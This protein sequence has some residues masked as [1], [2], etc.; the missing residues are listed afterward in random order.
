MP[1]RGTTPWVPTSESGGEAEDI[2]AVQVPVAGAVAADARGEVHP[3]TGFAGQADGVMHGA[4]GQP[5]RVA[6]VQPLAPGLEEL[7][8]GGD[9]G[10]LLLAH[11]LGFMEVEAVLPAGWLVGEHDAWGHTGR[12]EGSTPTQPKAKLYHPSVQGHQQ[13]RCSGHAAT[14]NK[15]PATSGGTGT[16]GLSAGDAQPRTGTALVR[17]GMGTLRLG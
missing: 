4:I 7:V 14:S 2:K 13:Q 6:P 9:E 5:A 3:A 16:E 12:S 17:M 8:E 1:A 11:S 10:A 15:M